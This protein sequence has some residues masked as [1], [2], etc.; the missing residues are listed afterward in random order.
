VSEMVPD[1]PTDPRFPAM[2][3]EEHTTIIAQPGYA[4]PGAPPA[5]PGWSGRVYG[6]GD[7]GYGAGPE[8][9]PEPAGPDRGRT[10]I[11]DQVVERMIEKIVNLAGDEVAG[12]HALHPGAGPDADRPV[13][14]QLDGGQAVI[15][16]ALEVEFGHPV[17][18]VVDDVRSRVIHQSERLLGLAVTEVNVLV[19]EVSFDPPA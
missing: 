12:V 11:A 10:T 16:V 13:A 1:G 4:P 6:P 19:A 9:E 8:P 7:H 5:G 14:V 18:Q 3:P 15:D 17:H 2:P